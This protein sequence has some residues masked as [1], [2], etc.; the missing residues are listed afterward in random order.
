[1]YIYVPCECMNVVD[2]G[3]KGGCIV[4]GHHDE[5]TFEDPSSS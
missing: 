3:D 4:I 1:M 2:N 5:Y